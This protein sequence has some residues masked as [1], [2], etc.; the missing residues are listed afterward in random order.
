MCTE[1][2]SA[3]GSMVLKN[4]RKAI[5]KRL[6]LSVLMFVRMR[7]CNLAVSASHLYRSFSYEKIKKMGVVTVRY[8]RVLELAPCIL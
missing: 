6:Y 3:Q 1:G 2:L 4:T 5:P 8:A 7:S